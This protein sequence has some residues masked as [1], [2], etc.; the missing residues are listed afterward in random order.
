MR[1]R[2]V[3]L[4]ARCWRSTREGPPPSRRRA[5]RRCNCSTSRR[6]CAWRAASTLLD[7]REVRGIHVD[8]IDL[9]DDLAV[10]LGIGCDLLP[11]GV[12]AE[13]VPVLLGLLAAGVG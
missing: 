13:I 8:R 4:P 1:S 3:I 2:A 9:F 5:S 10:G 12:V 6:I 7:L 11:L